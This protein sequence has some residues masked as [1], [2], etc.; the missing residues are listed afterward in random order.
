MSKLTKL[1]VNSRRFDARAP[2]SPAAVSNQVNVFLNEENL[3]H[4][5]C[6]LSVFDWLVEKTVTEEDNESNCLML[7][8]KRSK[9]P[10][11][12]NEAF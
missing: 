2:D 8:K 11:A 10:K 9:H 5:D 3:V 4:M 1:A 12:Y 6:I 7:A